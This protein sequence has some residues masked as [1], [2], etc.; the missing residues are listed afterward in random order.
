MICSLATEYRAG[1]GDRND[2]PAGLTVACG[3]CRLCRRD[4]S[5]VQFAEAILITSYREAV[6]VVFLIWRLGLLLLHRLPTFFRFCQ[7]SR[8]LA[9]SLLRHDVR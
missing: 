5:R 2:R 6:R 7:L 8:F 4:G 9:Q 3:A 1:C